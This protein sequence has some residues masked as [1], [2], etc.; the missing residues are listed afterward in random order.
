MVHLP[1]SSISALEDWRDTN[2]ASVWYLS[3]Y[4]RINIV[5]EEDRTLAIR[6][7]QV[8]SDKYAERYLTEVCT[9]NACIYDALPVCDGMRWNARIRF[10]LDGKA[11]AGEITSVDACDEEALRVNW[12]DGEIE[13]LANLD[14]CLLYTSD[15]ADD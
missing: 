12:N 4:G 14:T 10:E 3:R 2:R 13:L 1:V 11:A 7:W 6:D 9:E 5:R 8:N 15:A